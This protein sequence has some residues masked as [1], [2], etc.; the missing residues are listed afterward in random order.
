MPQTSPGDWHT[1]VIAL[2][3]MVTAL[4]L[5]IIIKEFLPYIRGKVTNDKRRSYA[6]DISELHSQ[7]RRFGTELG[8]ISARLEKIQREIERLSAQHSA[9]DADGQPKWYV[10]PE[11]YE[12]VADIRRIV[13]R[14][15]EL[16]TGTQD[17][18]A[19]LLGKL[20]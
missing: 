5:R 11:L 8:E 16:Q 3:A 7:G 14:I 9:L 17:L 12:T 20:K 6:E 13:K 1:T 15:E 10:R 18:I 4:L 2:A 19:T